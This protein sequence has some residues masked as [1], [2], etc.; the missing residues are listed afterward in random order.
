M[1]IESSILNVTVNSPEVSGGMTG[2]DASESTAGLSQFRKMLNDSEADQN[3]Q[4]HENNTEQT[5]ES[6]FNTTLEPDHH[7]LQTL[8]PEKNELSGFSISYSKNFD[9]E[10]ALEST[11]PMGNAENEGVTALLQFDEATSADSVTVKNLSDAP[12]LAQQTGLTIE[13]RSEIQQSR[14]ESFHASNN[15]S[16]WETLNRYEIQM[17]MNMEHGGGHESPGSGKE[18]PP[19]LMQM[20]TLAGGDIQ[21]AAES[22]QPQSQLQVNQTS[23]LT[24]TNQANEASRPGQPTLD[25]QALAGSREWANEMNNHI[26]WMGRMN[27]SSAEIKLNPAELGALEIRIVTNEDQTSV[28]FFA[29]NSATK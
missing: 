21:K 26:R 11:L 6:G 18:L 5:E 2:S 24:Q 7:T 22:S 13:N 28:S 10:K 9:T 17:E 16:S 15:L 29:G 8:S 23:G 1:N 20:M 25:T 14:S 4:R 27:I 12:L 19:Q 3:T